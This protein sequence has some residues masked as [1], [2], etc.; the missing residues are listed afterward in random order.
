M[1]KKK[2]NICIRKRP[3]GCAIFF[4]NKSDRAKRER[5]REIKKEE[6]R[7]KEKE[8][9]GDRILVQISCNFK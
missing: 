4:L 7:E 8:E 2:Y 5:E 6:E 1:I 3:M 9:S